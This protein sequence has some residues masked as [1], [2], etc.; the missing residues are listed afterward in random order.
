MGK[1][2]E[3]A[4]FI[5][6]VLRLDTSTPVK[7]YD[8][9]DIGPANEQAQALANRT[10][11]LKEQFAELLAEFEQ[12]SAMD[13]VLSVNDKTGKVVLKA[14]D[15]GAAPLEH[16][17]PVTDIETTDSANFVSKEEKETWSNKQDKLVSGKTIKTVLGESIL[18]SGDIQINAKDVVV[19]DTHQF[20][21]TEEKGTWDGKQNVLVSGKTIKTLHDQNLL[22]EGNVTLTADDV[23][24]EKS[25]AVQQAITA[26]L[27]EENP[28]PQYLAKVEAEKEYVDLASA[29]KPLGY[30]KLD[31]S[32]YLPADIAKLYEAHYY[33]AENKEDR[34]K[35]TQ[36][37][38]IVICLQVD[39]DKIYYLNPETDPSV[40]DNWLMGG[41][42]VI[43]NVV[44]VFGRSGIIEPRDG[45]YNADQI[46]ETETRTFTTPEERA[47][48]NEKQA[49]LVSGTN[50]KTINDESVLGE[51]DITISPDS[52]GAAEKSH[53]HDTND[54][55]VSD[56]A[57]FVSLEEKKSWSSKQDKLV[58]GKNFGTIF[59][60]SLLDG[61]VITLGDAD[62]FVESVFESMKAGDGVTL[63]FD[64]VNND[65]TIG[66][67]AGD[68]DT[69]LPTMTVETVEDAKANTEY[70]YSTKKGINFNFVAHALKENIITQA[71]VST[72]DYSSLVNTLPQTTLPTFDKDGNIPIGDK[73]LYTLN[74]S[75]DSNTP[76]ITDTIVR[77]DDA[78]YFGID[79]TP[80]LIPVFDGNTND[81]NITL[82]SSVNYNGFYPWKAFQAPMTAEERKQ[83]PNYEYWSDN[84][85]W[86][87]IGSSDCYLGFVSKKEVIVDSYGFQNF[88]A[89]Y[90][91]STSTPPT[92]WDL[93]GRNSDN[94]TWTTVDS[95]EGE[96]IQK[97][98]DTWST[99]TLDTPVSYKQYR[100]LVKAVV[101][102][103]ARPSIPRLQFYHNLYALVKDAN[104]DFYTFKDDLSVQK[105]QDE[106]PGAYASEGV[107]GGIRLGNIT[108][109]PMVF[110]VTVCTTQGGELS[111]GFYTDSTQIIIH[112]PI[113]DMPTWE[114]LRDLAASKYV[115][116][117]DDER[118]RMAFTLDGET[119]QVFKNKTWAPIGTLTNDTDSAILLLNNGM[120]FEE[121]N[122]LD[123]DQWEILTL[124]FEGNSHL[125]IAYGSLLLNNK[126]SRAP[127]EV[128]LDFDK[129]SNWSVQSPDKVN[130]FLSKVK[131][132][133]KPTENGNYKFCYN[134][135]E[136]TEK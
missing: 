134:F 56:D 97:A 58:K 62:D 123:Q 34:L 108:D 67:K 11:W 59:G 111:A 84:R 113:K 116:E 124:T 135:V 8:G 50:I 1:L 65:I 131:I 118:L 85:V 21:S 16:K 31:E 121:I 5:D 126:D 25:G 66:L 17:H 38:N 100:I 130:I 54:I 120:T 122:A 64:E 109:T 103:G 36:H 128:T 89:L 3:V 68:T 46:T 117:G 98:G 22:G 104:G 87:N 94:D 52:I 28:H 72:V 119:F 93:Q 133:F 20:T 51:G 49:N 41:S 47:A 23:G 96:V 2:V 82:I 69:G 81:D 132:V 92:A 32:G 101:N 35:I 73:I 136:S 127:K 26:H 90:W 45:D 7:G 106:M 95:R 114:S 37:K 19:D 14:E 78:K 9:N 12:I 6:E 125:G 129:I 43:H 105:V 60:K 30:L 48:W 75:E 61:K 99:Y 88:E 71:S 91:T 55:I 33:I 83:V 70:K 74:A 110:P 102:T 79:V 44:S 53:K 77:P 76:F 24:A 27:E 57:Q 4:E 115:N 112:N 10:R 63:L 18:G 13:Y 42:N 86:R 29:N 39:D 80:S 107:K 15:V 40:E